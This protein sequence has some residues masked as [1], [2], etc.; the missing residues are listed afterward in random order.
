MHCLAPALPSCPVEDLCAW[1]AAGRPAYD[2]PER[3]GQSWAGTDRM[4]RGRLMAVLRDAEGPVCQA[5][6]D[7]AWDLA[8]QR[9]RA[10]AGLLD[11]GLAV[12]SSEGMYS[13]PN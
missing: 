8:E 7:A 3:K 9:D 5:Q 2:G 12:R 10:L 4:V 11:D 13:L 6:L 1:V